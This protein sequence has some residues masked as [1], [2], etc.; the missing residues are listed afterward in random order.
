MTQKRIRVGV[1]ERF[2]PLQELLAEI[3]SSQ[4]DMALAFSSSA[5]D[6]QS[7]LAD[8]IL[9][10]EESLGSLHEQTKA[11]KNPKYI[12]INVDPQQDGFVHRIS[13]GAQG[14]VLSTSTKEEIVNAIR[15][16]VEKGWAVPDEVAVK[17]W[18]EIAQGTVKHSESGLLA[19][20]RITNR[21]CEI[22][23]L[24]GERRTNKEIA[25]LLDISTETVKSHVH[26][27]MEKLDVRNRAELI[28]LLAQGV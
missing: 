25:I 2:L 24:I 18:P 27:I 6:H 14:F 17:I 3:I 10:Q 16:V 12:L 28:A 7:D 4:K 21:E 5:L 22:I 9:L 20:A 11:E 23:R 1:V 8:V 13:H 15:T 26:R 19:N